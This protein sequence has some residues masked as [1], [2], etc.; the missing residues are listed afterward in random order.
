MGIDDR[1]RLYTR[2]QLR[3]IARAAKM[4]LARRS[5][6]N[7]TKYTNP[8]YIENWHHQQYGKKL[9]DFAAGKIKKLMVFMPPQHGKSELCSRRLPAKML[10]DDPDLRVGL[11]S[12]N[13]D[14]ASKFNRDVQRII[15]SREYARIYPGTRLNTANIRT[16]VGTWLRNSDE[17]EVVQRRGGLV[18]VGIGGGLTG[19]AIDVLVID[20]PYKDPKDAWSPTVRRSIQ[21][22]YDTVANTRLHNDSRQ[23]ITLTRWHQDDLAGVL[24]KREPDEWEVVKF[25]A[26]KEGEPTDIDPREE[27]AA[28]WPE[29]HSLERLLTSKAGNPHVFRSLYQ[30]DPR[31]AEGLLFPAETLNYFELADLKGRTPDGVIA[32]AD[33]ADTGSDYYAMLIAYLFGTDIYIVDVIFSQAQAEVTEPLTLGALDNWKVQR[34]RIESNAGGRLYAKSIKEKAGGYTAIEPVPSSANKETRILT[35]SAQVKQHIYFRQDYAHGSDYEKFYDQLTGYTIVGP[36]EHDDAPDAATM[37][38]DAAQN[39]NRRWSL[40][41]D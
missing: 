19:R 7:F 40:D 29:R 26:I 25:Q 12:Y 38:I 41:V 39:A 23:L 9:D 18:T 27:G 11:V 17:F 16:V 32:V 30:Q 10:G 4:E 35:A 33:V 31:P 15:D 13:H 24:L 3:D 14:F 6:I 36:N 1:E 20:D 8:L 28:L 21:D 37:L 22:W 34:F 5:L 2:E